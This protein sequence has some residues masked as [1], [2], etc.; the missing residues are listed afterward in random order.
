[1]KKN[2]FQNIILYILLSIAFFYGGYYTGK[3]GFVFEIRKNPPKIEIIN[4]APADSTVDFGLFWEVWNLVSQQYLERPVN[5]TKMLQGAITGMVSSL[6]DPY[7]SYLPPEVNKTVS[8]A[9]NG[10]YQGIGA[11]L[12]LRDNQL[13]I[14]APLDGSPA[15]AAGVRAG[16]KILKINGESAQGVLVTEAVSKIRGDAGTVVTLQLQRD[17]TEPFDLSITRNVIAVSSVAWE[18]KGDGTAYVRLSRFGGETNK[19]W[20]KSVSELNMKMPELDA[21][22]LD[23]RG[24]PGGYLQSAIFV[25]GEFFNKQPVCYQEDSFGAITPYNADRNGT[26]T[27][28]PAVFVLIDEGSASASEI[29][30]AALR[31]NIKAKLIG[32]KSFGKGTIQD[33]KEFSDGSGVHITVAKWLTPEKEWIHKKGLIPDIEVART[34]DDY[35]KG[36]DPQLDKALELAKEF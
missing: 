13:I 7:T 15:K 35:T 2:T 5:P 4:K 16:D 25:A 29:L 21:L 30:A 1:M 20:I 8:S 33:A 32:T 6:G 31:S 28:I 19:D 27:R 17:D 24:N 18:D 12:G 14:V 36:I 23:L 9:L 34:D 22:I 10:V 3:R 11:E 26:L